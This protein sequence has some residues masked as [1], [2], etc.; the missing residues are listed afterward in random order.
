MK[1][2][3]TPPTV[4]GVYLAR[5]IGGTDEF[6]I[7]VV[8][9]TYPF[10]DFKIFNQRGDERSKTDVIYLKEWYGPITMPVGREE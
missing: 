7:V 2:N 4:P 1:P 5:R 10:F 6:L 3:N 9:G 8:F